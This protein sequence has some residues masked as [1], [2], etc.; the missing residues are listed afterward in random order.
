MQVPTHEQLS[1]LEA[2]LGCRFPPSYHALAAARLPASLERTLPRARFVAF[3]DEVR[4]ARRDRV[5]AS[6]LPF[7]HAPQPAHT[8]YYC[9]DLSTG[10]LEPPVVVFA[11]HAVV[12]AWPS[13]ADWL[14][15]G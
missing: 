2:A 6:L 13:L 5:P 9:F 11:V 14:G 15:S 4:A 7:L 1:A 3:A 12:A 10:A 8:D